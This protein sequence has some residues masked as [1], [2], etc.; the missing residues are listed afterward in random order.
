MFL[1]AK[2]RRLV[3]RHGVTNRR[4]FCVQVVASYRKDGKSRQKVVAHL[5]TVKE[6]DIHHSGLFHTWA[7]EAF[8]DDATRK[9]ETLNLDPSTRDR[10]EAA[11]AEKVPRPDATIS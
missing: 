9:L 5:G 7:L 11:L 1:R 10:L 2:C 8:W 6:Q 3:S 4:S